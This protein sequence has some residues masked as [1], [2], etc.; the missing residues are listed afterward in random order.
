M[1][2]G[3]WMKLLVIRSLVLYCRTGPLVYS[4]QEP[5][6]NWD[7]STAEHARSEVSYSHQFTP[8]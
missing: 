1:I 8:T 6:L 3:C 7:Q 2:H 4:L 5:R